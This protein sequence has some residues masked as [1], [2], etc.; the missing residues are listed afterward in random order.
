M[1]PSKSTPFP[2]GGVQGML[3]EQPGFGLAPAPAIREVRGL[4]PSA[5]EPAS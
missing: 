3:V 1:D 2:G 5:P 4:P